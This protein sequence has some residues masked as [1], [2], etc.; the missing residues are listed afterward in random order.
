MKERLAV[1]QAHSL[2][3]LT[4]IVNEIN[5]SG[6]TKIL[7]DDIV[8]LLKEDNTYFLVYYR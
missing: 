3:D 7:K 6:D 8:S 4:N 5:A 1:L 2:R